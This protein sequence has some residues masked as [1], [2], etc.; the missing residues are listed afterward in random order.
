MV[1]RCDTSTARMPYQVRGGR[2]KP[3]SRGRL[4]GGSSVAFNC[5]SRNGRLNTEIN[6]RKRRKEEVRRERETTGRERERGERSPGG[7]DIRSASQM[8][9]DMV[10][11]VA[12]AVQS[13]FIPLISRPPL[14]EC[15]FLPSVS[16]GCQRLSPMCCCI[17]P[18]TGEFSSSV[19]LARHWQAEDRTA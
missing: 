3:R 12:V 4:R 9:A 2:C 10:R 11:N 18:I 8:G 13:S 14:Q 17:L 5:S 19:C 6:G 7:E 16:P 15:A 1:S